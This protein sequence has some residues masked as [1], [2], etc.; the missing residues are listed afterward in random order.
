[1]PKLGIVQAILEGVFSKF[2]VKSDEIEIGNGREV[3]VLLR[4]PWLWQDGDCFCQLF[5]FN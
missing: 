3:W 5:L 1:M 4:D 2:I